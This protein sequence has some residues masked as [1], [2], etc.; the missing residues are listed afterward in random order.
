MGSLSSLPVPMSSSE[1][2]EGHAPM[3]LEGHPT[4]RAVG[5]GTLVPALLTCLPARQ[6]EASWVGEA[7][8]CPPCCSCTTEGH[9]QP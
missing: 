5:F 1:H 8:G 2:S 6:G 4:G 7:S 9:G 3:P